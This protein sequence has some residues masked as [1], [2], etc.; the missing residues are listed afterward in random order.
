MTNL[1]ALYERDFFAWSKE[2]AEA[3]RGAAH[4]R[5]N[6]PIDWE[7]VAEEIESL[8]RSE[9]R[10]LGSRIRQVVEHLAK[11]QLSPAV[12][13]RAGWRDS[14]RQQRREITALLEDS[15]SLRTQLDDIVREQS[16]R[17]VPDAFA[18]LQGRG[19]LGRAPRRGA[20]PGGEL[21][22]TAE[23]VLGEWYPPEPKAVQE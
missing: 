9:R 13:P 20:K 8:G 21:A 17:A 18:E 14:I 2:Q 5:S 11:L 22:Y 19:E 7:N 4:S 16:R 6:V 3:L 10:E 15:P 12:E 23:Q 1:K